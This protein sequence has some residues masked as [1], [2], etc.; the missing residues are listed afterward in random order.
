V[1]ALTFLAP[2]TLAIVACEIIFPGRDLYHR[3][4]FCVAL[5]ALVAASVLAARK[6]FRAAAGARARAGI[7]AIAF[8][9]VVAGF[10]GAASGLL[11]PDNRTIVGAPGANVQ[12]D[13]LGATLSFPLKAEGSEGGAPEV[14]LQR[15]GSATPI[16]ATPR[17]L[18]TFVLR[19]IPRDVVYVEAADARGASL[20]IT[21]PNGATFLSPV[22]LMQ[23]HQKI[24]NTNFDLPFDAFAVP[25]AHRTVKAMLFTPQQ[26]AMLHPDGGALSAAVLFAVDD[27]D[28]RPL[29][30]AI[31]LA[32]DGETIDAGGLRLR[33][34]L[35]SYPAVELMAVPSLAAVILAAIAMVAGFLLAPRKRGA[36]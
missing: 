4:W 21:Q 36:L 33:A 34:G 10:A 12:V 19:E 18:G 26:A 9:A 5:V 2:L 15:S 6:P 27:Q 29:P 11:A 13:E 24:P 1:N 23:Q 22:L 17:N 31:V 16:G 7:A 35:L 8:G 14:L 32:R 28:D 3:G 20:T 30:G 25:A